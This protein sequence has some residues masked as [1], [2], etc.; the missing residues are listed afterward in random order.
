MKQIMFG[1]ILMSFSSLA[2]AVCPATKAETVAKLAAANFAETRGMS[3]GLTIR[4][5][6]TTFVSSQGE[7]EYNVYVS[8]GSLS[9]ETYS[10]LIDKNCVLSAIQ[11]SDGLE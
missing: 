9:G 8:A 3:G 1:T 6:Q 2:S 4:A 10:V 11:T 7:V 5:S